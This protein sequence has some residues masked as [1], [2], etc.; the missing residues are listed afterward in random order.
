MKSSVLDLNGFCSGCGACKLVC[1]ADAVEIKRDK[2]GFYTAE[3]S[4]QKCVHCGKCTD[5]CLRKGAQN[6][7]ILTD[8]TMIAAQSKSLETVLSC[9]SGGVAY[10]LSRYAIEQGWNVVGVIYDF[11]NNIAKTVIAHTVEALEAFKG[12]KYIQSYCADAFAQTIELA[13]QDAQKKFLVFGTPCQI[14]GLASVLEGKKIRDQ[15]ILVDLFCHGVPSYTVWDQYLAWV[16]SKLGGDK[17]T[18]VTFRDKSIGWHNFVMRI[19]GENKKY[20]N[21]SEGDLFYRVFFDNVL[22]C[23]ACFDC[24]VRKNV[25]K[26]DIRLGDYW[27][28]RFQSRED[29]VSAV[30]LCTPKGKSFFDK[31]PYIDQITETSVEEVLKGQSV[32]TYSEATLQEKAFATLEKSGNLRKTVRLYRKNFCGKRRLKI[33]VKEMTSHL[34]D[35]LRAK[36]RFLYRRSK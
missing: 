8:G 17:L 3:I 26:A 25:T 36:I 9:T 5:V 33:K 6:A 29:G 10:E 27:G 28:R 2:K 1:P 13:E 15:F 34:P 12:S 31:N 4:Q 22:F 23:G 11:E 21:P 19:E 24:E 35:G 18:K 16:Q 14:Y 7:K 20:S 32:H 30:L